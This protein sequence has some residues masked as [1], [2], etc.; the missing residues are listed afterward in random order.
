MI[1]CANRT[2][3]KLPSAAALIGFF[4]PAA[5]RGSVFGDPVHFDQAEHA[6]F[7]LVQRGAAQVDDAFLFGLPPQLKRIAAF[8][9]IS[10][11]GSEI[12]ITWNTPERPL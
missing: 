1:L 5:S 7:D 9:M 8:R 3:C 6:V 12:G 11:I 2:D 4:G 10:S